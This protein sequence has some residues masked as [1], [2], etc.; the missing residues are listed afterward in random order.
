MNGV[1]SLMSQPMSTDSGWTEEGMGSG[2]KLG[3]GFGSC[4]SLFRRCDSS[5]C[6]VVLQ[7]QAAGLQYNQKVNNKLG[8]YSTE[9]GLLKCK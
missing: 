1:G 3:T 4:D 5:K 6:T 8:L 2:V 9:S 7:C